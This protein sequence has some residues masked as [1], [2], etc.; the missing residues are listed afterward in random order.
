MCN[1]V[2]FLLPAIYFVCKWLFLDPVP[3]VQRQ[4]NKQTNPNNI[5]ESPILAHHP[6][7]RLTDI[8]PIMHSLAAQGH[9]V[10][11]IRI[12][13]YPIKMMVQS[14]AKKLADSKR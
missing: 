4:R 11:I 5:R 14:Q 9:L 2:N 7:H 12:Y 10:I 1:T 8:A 13:S 6:T 3:R